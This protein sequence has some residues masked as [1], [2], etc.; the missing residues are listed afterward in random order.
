LA[1]V[2]VEHVDPGAPR[3]TTGGWSDWNDPLEIEAQV[4][5]GADPEGTGGGATHTVHATVMDLEGLSADDRRWLRCR[6]AREE[7]GCEETSVDGVRLLYR[8]RPG[9][10]EEEGG[11]YS[12]TVV[13]ADEVVRV[14]YDASR[15]FPRDPRELDLPL[16][17]SDLRAAALDDAMSLR[18][19]PAF[20]RAGRDLA[21]YEGVEAPPE[22][23]TVVP[24]KPRRLAA[25]V[26][27]YLELEPTSVRRSRLTD[28]GP[29]AVGVH[30]EFPGGKGYAP[31]SVD[32]LTTVGRVPQIDPLPCRVQR[33]STAARDS[34]FAWTADSVATW[35]LAAAGRPG[36]MW[37]IGAQD[38]D[39]FNRV[40]SV[41][42][43][44]TSTGIDVA[45]F[46]SA[47][48]APRI[49]DTVYALGPF[50]SD[51]SVGPERR[52]AE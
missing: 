25:R 15:L 14:S 41:G 24:T 49:P 18:T 20:L 30:L 45:P 32:V 10:A 50:T 22:K 23:P 1:A 31:F 47:E 39:T 17:S 34:C 37:V 3:R 11:A 40:E 21:H 12:W 16:S 7:G 36:R 5:Y 35:T 9:M 8:W 43:L 2:V 44:V 28:F 4:D 13:R 33:S 38:D 27:D 52:L 26:V 46:D 48:V 51:L 19:T 29:D 42:A 6:P